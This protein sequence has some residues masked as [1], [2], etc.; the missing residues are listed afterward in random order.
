MPGMCMV[1][2]CRGEAAAD[3]SNVKRLGIIT[4]A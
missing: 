3:I 2:I 4:E 1:R